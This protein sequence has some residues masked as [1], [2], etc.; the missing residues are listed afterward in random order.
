MSDLKL[1]GVI[2][3]PIRHSRSP[4]LHGFWL[5]RHGIKGAY[6]PMAVAPERMEPA[7][8]GLAALGFQGVNVTVPLK[9]RALAI[10][11]EA[12]AV[13]TRIG[14]ANMI[15][16]GEDGR[17]HAT[18]TDAYGFTAS[19]RSTCP[20]FRADSGPAVV[21]GAGGAA[22][23]IL[24]SLIDQGVQEIRLINRSR[25]RAETLATTF[26][27]RQVQPLAWDEREDALDGAVLLVNTTSLGMNGEPPLTIRLDAL[28][29]RAVVN[30]IVYVPLETDLLAAARARGNPVVDGLEML[31]WQAQPSFTAWFGLVPDVD[32][33][34][35][36]AVLDDKA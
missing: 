11:D 23:A 32:R 34:L 25:E 17:L 3:W 10:A 36:D 30:D 18:N 26:G 15:S 7:L 22:R 24:A 29:A 4:R 8:R 19:L 28:P 14:A 27:E 5:R 6:V 2:G 35:R 33:E 1:A 21:L 13:A 12:D 16:V 20:T 9:E 31:L